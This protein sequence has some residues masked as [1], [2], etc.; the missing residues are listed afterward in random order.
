[1]R[2]NHFGSRVNEAMIESGSQR[3]P[4]ICCGDEADVRGVFFPDLEFE[5]RLGY[6]F[7]V[8]PICSSCVADPFST[9]KAEDAIM[10]KAAVAKN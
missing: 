10:R 5:K 9:L 8:Y 1:M 3:L 4:C 7:A 2:G 6:S